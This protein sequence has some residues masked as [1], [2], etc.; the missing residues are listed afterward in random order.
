MAK[1]E[2]VHAKRG[3]ET[4]NWGSFGNVYPVNSILVGFLFKIIKLINHLLLP[5]N[6]LK[7]QARSILEMKQEARYKCLIL[8]YFFWESFM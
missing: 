5:F 4:A 7:P 3:L 2:D 1:P 8:I 6:G